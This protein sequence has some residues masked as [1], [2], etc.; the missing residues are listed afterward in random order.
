MNFSNLGMSEIKPQTKEEK[1]PK[2]PLKTVNEPAAAPVERPKKERK[3]LYEA[4]PAKGRSSYQ[5]F[6]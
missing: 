4:P 1:K 3:P 6:I 5:A 2:Q